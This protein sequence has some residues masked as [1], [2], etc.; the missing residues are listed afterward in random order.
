MIPIENAWIEDIG[1]PPDFPHENGGTWKMPGGAYQSVIQLGKSHWWNNEWIPVDLRFQ[2][3]PD[4]KFVRPDLG[5]VAYEGVVKR[6]SETYKPLAVGF[7]ENGH[8]I[9]LHE[10]GAFYA[11]NDKVIWQFGPYRWISEYNSKGWKDYLQL[12]EKPDLRGSQFFIEYKSTIGMIKV[13]FVSDARGDYTELDWSQVGDNIVITVPNDWLEQANYPVRIDPDWAQINGCRT[14]GN[15]FANYAAAGTRTK[16]WCDF[17]PAIPWVGQDAVGF[18]F[19]RWR[20][21]VCFD[22]KRFCCT[23]I[24]SGYIKMAVNLDFSVQDFNVEIQRFDWSPWELTATCGD[25]CND[26]GGPDSAVCNALHSAQPAAVVDVTWRNTAGIVVDTYYNSPALN[27]NWMNNDKGGCGQCIY[28]GVISDRDKAGTQPIGGGN[29]EY[30]TIYGQG[31]ASPTSLV[32]TWE[33]CM[34]HPELV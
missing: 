1:R 19:R 30:V 31:G 15:E 3:T 5:V 12:N 14:G 34:G 29:P 4:G 20:M 32:F 33:P 10:P 24:L 17:A 8:F 25:H 22:L 9:A 28:Y 18:Y 13:P 11:E 26:S 6:G 16:W 23:E 2:G 7:V 27:V 21:Q